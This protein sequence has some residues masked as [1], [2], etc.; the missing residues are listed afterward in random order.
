MA[1]R[2]QQTMVCTKTGS[3]KAIMF[4]DTV[5]Y[6]VVHLKS[7]FCQLLG[8]KGP[9]WKC[10]KKTRTFQLTRHGRVESFPM[11]FVFIL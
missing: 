4:S 10:A 6:F 5:R 3:Q 8:K 9:N 11:S 2:Q 7:E 1:A